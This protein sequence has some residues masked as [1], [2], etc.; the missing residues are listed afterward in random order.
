MRK[1]ASAMAAL[2]FLALPVA[3]ES[4]ALV[5]CWVE[6]VGDPFGNSR[7]IT[8]CRLAN[9]ETT[10]FPGEPPGDVNPAVG[11][12]SLGICWYWTTYESDWE[13]LTRFADGSAILGLRIN[14][15]LA[16]D[17]G[18]IPRCSD[19]PV[20]NEPPNVR[21]W[22]AITRYVH[23]PPA[24]ELNPP[25]GL[26]LTGLATHAGVAVPG[27]WADT[28]TIPGYTIDVSAEVL[29][30]VIDWGDGHTDTFPPDAYPSLTGYPDGIARHVYETK[31]CDPPG[32]AADCH[33]TLSAYPVTVAY[34]WNAQWRANGGPWIA[35]N[36]AP[37]ETATSYPVT[38]AIS[39][40]TE[41]G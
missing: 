29:A 36:V 8:V 18:Q 11:T 25:V 27:P 33:P 6:E 1:L 23:N 17:T 2:L 16:I 41:T 35:V 37:T 5:A 3:A 34:H 21:A 22:E 19:E 28:I 39:T 31:T 30:L 26:G 10:T 15:F 4:D 9:G 12:D 20:P 14:G 38:E 13:L 32:S 7:Q 40:L 24:P